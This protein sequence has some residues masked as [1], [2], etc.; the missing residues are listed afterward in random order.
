[1]AIETICPLCEVVLSRRRGPD[2]LDVGA[3]CFLCRQELDREVGDN[4]EQARIESMRPVKSWQAMAK[5][6]SA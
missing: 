2:R 6:K 1:M 5:R 3:L 4:F